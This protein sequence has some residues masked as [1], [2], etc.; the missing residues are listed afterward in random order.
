LSASEI[1]T[2]GGARPADQSRLD[3]SLRTQ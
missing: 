3:A 1:M 2:V